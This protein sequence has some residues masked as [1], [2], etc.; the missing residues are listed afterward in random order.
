SLEDVRTTTG[1]RAV[2]GSAFMRLRTS[3]PSSRGSFR[4]SR[5]SF[6][7]SSI[8]RPACGR[9]QNKNSSA[10]TPSRAICTVLARLALLNACRV[11]LTSLGLS[12]TNRITARSLPMNRNLRCEV[13]CRALVDRRFGPDAAAV[14]LNDAL[15][16]GEADASAF[17]IFRSVQPLKNFEQLVGVLHVKAGA[18]VAHEERLLAADSA[19]ANF[20][21]GIG[22]L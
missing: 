21:C 11:S 16:D 7:G 9:V 18:V 14:A 12:S 1:I 13:K 22:A 5:T 17:K 10:S 20:D 4:S 6:V 15:D 2:R 8:L 3:W 19:G